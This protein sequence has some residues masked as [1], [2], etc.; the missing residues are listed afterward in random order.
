MIMSREQ[1]MAAS[2]AHLSSV[3]ENLAIILMVTPFAN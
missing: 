3:S 2:P 1:R